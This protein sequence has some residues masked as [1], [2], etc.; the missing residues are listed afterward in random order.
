MKPNIYH[1]DH[2]EYVEDIVPETLLGRITSYIFLKVL[3][4]IVFFCD[5]YR[6]YNRLHPIVKGI[7]WS[8]LAGIGIGLMLVLTIFLIL[9]Y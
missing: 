2:Q 1:Y 5:A 6:G 9:E 7:I 8:A 3:Q 4:C